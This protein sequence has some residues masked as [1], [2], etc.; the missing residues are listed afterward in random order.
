MTAVL[1]LVVILNLTLLA[2][3]FVTRGTSRKSGDRR[4]SVS[5]LN[6]AEAG[7]ERLYAEIRYNEYQPLKGSETTVY[8]NV[9]F[10]NG[11]Y[12]VSYKSNAA[13]DTLDVTSVGTLANATTTIRTR[14]SIRPDMPIPTPTI[15][16]AVSAR[17]TVNITGTIA[18]DGRDH[19][20]YCTTTGDPGVYGVSTTDSISVSGNAGIGG[21]GMDVKVHKQ[22]ELNIETVAEQDAAPD[23]M[24]NSPESFLSISEDDLKPY[25]SS[26]PTLT[27]PF[28]DF[29]YKTCDHV[30]P[31]NLDSSGGV[32]I[33]HNEDGDAELEITTGVF[34]GLII[35]DKIPL[36]SGNT[37]I[38]GAIVALQDSLVVINGVGTP[39]ICYCS[40]IIENLVDYCNNIK[41]WV[42]ELSWK[43]E[44]S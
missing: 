10:N 22:L 13:A 16:G 7:K 36:I 5:A 21:N 37:V 14:I 42:T 26:D 11:T 9:A 43:E 3:Y 41:N 12:T 24:F 23:T 15:R 33:V 32:L 40:E 2:V 1:A 31:L 27:P 30:G 4:E 17:S 39:R 35:A 19:D 6:I 18:I 34:K 29:I 8:S 38:H 28:H 20:P 25:M 44:K